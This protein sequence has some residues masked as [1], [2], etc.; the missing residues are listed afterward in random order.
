[1]R[2]LIIGSMGLVGTALTKLIPDAIQGIQ[3]EAFGKNQIYIDI[4][5]YE[6]LFKAFSTFRPEIVYLA[7]AIADVNACE[8]WGTSVVNVRG[9]THVLRL[10]EMF[11]SKLVFFS[12]SYV[13]DGKKHSPYSIDDEPNPIQQYGKQKLTM[14]NLISQS[15]DIDWLIVRTVGVFGNERKKKNFAKQV[16]SSVFAGKEVYAPTDQY[17][18]PIL[19]DDLAKVTK[20]LV[21]KDA[22][23]VYHVAGD[24]CVSKFEFARRVAG[25]FGYENLVKPK[26]TSEMNQRALRPEMGCLDCSELLNWGIEIP[27]L[28][29]GIQKFL[30][31]NYNE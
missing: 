26:L 31:S 12:S 14:E 25:Y 16:I 28:D 2:N 6:T 5:K 22:Q 19:S 11:E 3:M 4:I 29:G 21:D 10:C 24:T 23:G 15:T 7:G 1:M 27:S 18:N 8:S 17:M 9:S 30:A 13:F 20:S